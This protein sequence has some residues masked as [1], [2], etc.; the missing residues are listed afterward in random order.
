MTHQ[1]IR[2]KLTATFLILAAGAV[3]GG[4]V[5]I[6]CVSRI[7]A[8]VGVYANVTSPLMAE[9]MALIDTA[10][11]LKSTAFRAG[12]PGSTYAD[13][14]DEISALHAEADTRIR[15]IEGYFA[16]AGAE[17]RL[18]NR[19]EERFTA[20][21]DRMVKASER[22]AQAAAQA[23]Q[24]RTRIVRISGRAA[25]VIEGIAA[26]TGQD[27]AIIEE[28]AN[29][30]ILNGVATVEGMSSL[31]T[32]LLSEPLQVAGRAQRLRGELHAIERAVRS[33][34]MAG[35]DFDSSAR[36]IRASLHTVRR[37]SKE[38][39]G[40]MRHD[41]ERIQLA[42]LDRDIAALG[43]LTLGEYGLF[44]EARRLAAAR[45]S[46]AAGRLEVERLDEDYL[47]IL[48]EAQDFVSRLNSDAHA[49]ATVVIEQA[50]AFVTISVVVYL[51]VATLLGMR[52]ARKV[53]HPIDRLTQH[54]AR[55]SRS[56]DMQRLEDTAIVTRLD[57]IGE[58][59]RAFN[60]M[61]ADLQYA[62]R[63]LVEQSEAKV[64]V[65]YQR[66][67]SAIGSLRHGLIM[68]DREHNV[69]IWNDRL[70]EIYDFDM[71]FAAPGV[72]LRDVIGELIRQDVID[73]GHEL[74]SI[75]RDAVG[76]RQPVAYTIALND[77]R[78]IAIS[79]SPT[80]DGGAVS[81]HE[82]ITERLQSQERIAFM[83]LHD[84]L[85]ELPNRV[86]FR[87]RLVAALS[88]VPRGHP[89]AVLAFD[90][91]HFKHVN[92][93][94]G[95]P[96]GDTLLKS[97][98]E[99]VRACL[100]P[101]DTF[102]RL[103]GDEFAIVQLDIEAPRMASA[104]AARMIAEV[105]RPYEI[106][107]HKVVI[108]ASVGIALSPDDGLD[109]DD[110]LRNADMALYRSKELGRG[111]FS[112]FE[113]GMN[114][115][116]QSRRTMEME[117]RNAL[118]AG[119]FEVYYQPLVRADSGAVSCFEALLRWHH[120]ERGTVSACDFISLIEEIGIIG[121]VGRWVMEEACR[122]AT[123][124]PGTVGI[125]V[126]LSPVQFASDEL[127]DNVRRILADTGLEPARLE[128]DISEAILLKDAG[129]TVSTL[130]RLRELGVQL[131][132][133]DFGTGYSS[134]GYLR[135]FPFDKIKIDRS[136]MRDLDSAGSAAIVRAV[137]G[138]ANMLGISA[139]AEGV[140]TED[141]FARAQLEGYQEVQG[142]LFGQPVQGAD[143]PAL[144]SRTTPPRA[145]AAVA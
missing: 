121:R 13:A 138:L 145:G 105:S 4:G 52:V 89:L 71:D 44:A 103:G 47:T 39:S 43:T 53:T 46:L 132:M 14:I 17:L 34:W 56:G 107:G 23:E 75:A 1:S 19:I 28:Q 125:V 21:L 49:S 63:R 83:A 90:L 42:M 48:N 118:A 78:S 106:D 111:T 80:P 70:A 108:G 116:M 96:V 51:I 3:A 61:I 92:D 7:A 38:M 142:F 41:S 22:E 50:L 57:E 37:L 77:G 126:N 131:S 67:V 11:G 136:F 9:T 55:I 119:Q 99:R 66:L 135:M 59:A 10:H 127:V 100:R 54:A 114:Q 86:A 18:G 72:P 64:Q 60:A 36:G 30:D 139:V 144:L 123:T 40:L 134:L 98:A 87:D 2:R 128:L 120:P 115:R 58:L 140:E 32:H 84:M 73:A 112:F 117:L 85:T 20:A 110:L 137:A 129:A 76:T 94:L 24:L 124:W 16:K 93:T 62:R 104:L 26:A 35:G 69:V 27:I 31:I 79:S 65:Q 29:F 12:R 122:T 5:G 130:Q 81:V 88:R 97:V 82:D 15:A 133:D 113:P 45:A 141:Q 8:T 102:A 101:S 74:V 25:H 33:E 143:V 91:D 95:H 6:Y 109:P 68:Y